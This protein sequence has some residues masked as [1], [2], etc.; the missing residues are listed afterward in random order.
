MQI[1]SIFTA[2]FFGIFLKCVSRDRITSTFVNKSK[3]KNYVSHN[4][5]E[6]S[7]REFKSRITFLRI[8]EKVAMGL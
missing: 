6:N 5:R 4:S 7:N 2:D 3:V 1:L 8:V